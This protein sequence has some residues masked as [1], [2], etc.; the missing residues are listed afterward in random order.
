LY[1]DDCAGGDGVD[2]E[3]DVVGLHRDDAVGVLTLVL[4]LIT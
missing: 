2:G 3:E 4:I 1:E